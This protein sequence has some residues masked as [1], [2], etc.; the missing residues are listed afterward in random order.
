MLKV[1]CIGSGER[2]KSAHRP[3]LIELMRQNIIT[4]CVI[5]LRERISNQIYFDDAF[6]YDDVN[7]LEEYICK[8]RQT[9][10]FLC[11]PPKIVYKY[12]NK[13][14]KHKQLIVVETPVVN[15][16]ISSLYLKKFADHNFFLHESIFFD[17][18][19]YQTMI[20]KEKVQSS[21]FIKNSRLK[22][23]H[24][25][26]FVKAYQRKCNI[27]KIKQ[28]YEYSYSNKE[29]RFNFGTCITD[30]TT[31]VQNGMRWPKTQISKIDNISKKVHE[32]L[33]SL[34]KGYQN[35]IYH[36]NIN[37]IP[38]YLMWRTIFSN[39]ID[40]KRECIYTTKKSL[41]DYVYWR[42]E[43][44]GLKFLPRSLNLLV[45]SILDLAFTF[46]RR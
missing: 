6:S 12:R 32:F 22:G 18:D 26:S 14:L 25:T 23:Y 2:F 21:P 41:G 9:I 37:F 5:L 44:F 39:V 46:F 31:D 38:T 10:F 28:D 8:N 34:N 13:L 11:L 20:R 40:R 17:Y 36:S 42:T 16:I 33:N 24:L 3:V 4:E 27:S 43:T 29:D 15:N 19:I 30:M 45:L 1:V 35:D 7:S